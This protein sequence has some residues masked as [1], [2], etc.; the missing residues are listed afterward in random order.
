MAGS[1][2]SRGTNVVVV[3]V[4]SGG[5]GTLLTQSRRTDAERY[6]AIGRIGTADEVARA[7]VWTALEN[8]YLNGTLIPV[9]GGL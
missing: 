2:L 8:P 4:L 6:A 1:P 3:G 5:A 7:I 9:T